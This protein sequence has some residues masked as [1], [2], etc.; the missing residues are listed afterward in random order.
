LSERLNAPQLRQLKQRVTLR[1][2]LRPLSLSECHEYIVSRLKQAG[3]EPGL[4]T[5]R[6]IETIY[7]YSGGI[8]RLINV[9]CD[10]SMINA[11]ALDQRQIDPP[12]IHEVA[13]DLHLSEGAVRSAS[14]QPNI[15]PRVNVHASP[16]REPAKSQPVQLVKKDRPDPPAV[17]LKG[18]SNNK[19]IPQEVFVWLREGLL[20]A[21]GPMAHVVLLEHVKLLGESVSCFPKDKFAQLIESV[22]TEIF[23]H[24]IRKQFRQSMAAKMNSL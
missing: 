3:G 15:S 13:N 1:H 19:Q 23:D 17:D 9:I 16:H 14:I 20:D 8:P 21:M 18:I 5:R 2:N 10:N 11:Y 4:F 6:A 7:S 12:L 22:S 24:S